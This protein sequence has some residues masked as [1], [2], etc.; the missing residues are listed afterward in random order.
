[1]KGAL[2]STGV[3]LV[4]SLGAEFLGGAAGSALGQWIRGGKADLGESLVDGLGNAL[5]GWAYGSGPI[6]S[7]G[8]VVFRG[9]RAGA[10]YAL[11][12]YEPDKPGL[13]TGSWGLEGCSLKEGAT[14]VFSPY[15]KDRD[16]RTR[17]M[18]PGAWAAR[19]LR[20]IS[21]EQDRQEAGVGAMA[22][23]GSLRKWRWGRC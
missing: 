14:P 5:S 2:L 9:A 8:N 7:L 16:I 13:G 3:G 17:C 23:E 10:V 11:I 4:P 18:A 20:A 1:M 6:K 22:L 19:R 21:M 12:R 15:I